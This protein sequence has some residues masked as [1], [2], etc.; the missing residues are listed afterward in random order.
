VRSVTETANGD[1]PTTLNRTERRREQT[2]RQLTGAART[3]I[4][5]RGVAGLRI[6]DLTET[7][8]VGRGSFYNHFA[9]KADLVKAVVTETLET[10][11][12]NVLSDLPQDADPAVRASIADRRFIRL[13]RD[14][15][16][17]ARLLVHLDHG[18]DL[19]A[20]A[21]APYARMTIQDG[22]DSGRFEV[23]DLDVVLVILTGSSLALIRALLGDQ[24]PADAD[25]TH[26]ESVLRLLG[27]LP[28]EA[29]EI[30]RLPLES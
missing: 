17:F 11:A 26:A 5:E 21:V 14:D 30:S 28:D 19:F 13:A 6:A 24:V 4:T 23:T 29:R 25:E 10:L 20:A 22:I 3:L 9:S 1:G 18:D 16:E 15:P 12:T 27:L 7:A 2:R 8:D